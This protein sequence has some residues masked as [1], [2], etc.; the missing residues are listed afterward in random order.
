MFAQAKKTKGIPINFL[1]TTTSSYCGGAAPTPEIVA[2]AESAKPINNTVFY[3]YTSK[4]KSKP[5]FAKV[6]TN[7][8]GK[9]KHN[10]PKGTYYVFSADQIAGLKMPAIDEKI[11][12]DAAC[13]EKKYNTPI[14][15]FSVPSKKTIAI[16]IYKSCWYSPECGTYT[17][18]MPN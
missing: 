17:G 8:I 7:D 1:F 10:L 16:N 14:H 2:R 6:T 11:I 13:I 9:V 3:I 12:W 5:A 4:N 15:T 18:P